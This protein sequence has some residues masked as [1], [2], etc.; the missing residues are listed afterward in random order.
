VSAGLLGRAAARGRAAPRPR[1]RRPGWP[2]PSGAR[3]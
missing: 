1:R 3:L 2:E